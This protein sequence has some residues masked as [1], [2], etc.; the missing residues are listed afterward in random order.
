MKEFLLQAASVFTS[1]CRSVFSMVAIQTVV[2]NAPPTIVNKGLLQAFL[3]RQIFT[4]NSHINVKIDA[5]IIIALLQGFAIFESLFCIT[6]FWYI[7]V[8][9]DPLLHR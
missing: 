4:M 5:T 3:G 6:H 7:K 1:L 9:L 2:N 8:A